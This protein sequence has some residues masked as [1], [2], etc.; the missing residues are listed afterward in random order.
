[1]DTSVF[2]CV[3]LCPPV[4]ALDAPD[5]PARVDTATIA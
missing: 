5:A 2:P 1:M 3:P 4:V